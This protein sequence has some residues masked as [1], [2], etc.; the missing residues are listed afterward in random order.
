MFK[1]KMPKEQKPMGVKKSA[2]KALMDKEK[3]EKC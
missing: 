3:K 2:W 1:P